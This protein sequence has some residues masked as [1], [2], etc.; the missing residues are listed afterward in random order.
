YF[1]I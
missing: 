1:Y